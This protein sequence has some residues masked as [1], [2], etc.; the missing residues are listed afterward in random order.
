MKVR[1]LKG[2]LVFGVLGILLSGCS[3]VSSDRALK[4]VEQTEEIKNFYSLVD[5]K[6]EQCFEKRVVRPCDTDWVTCIEDAWVV[7]IS[8]KQECFVHDGRLSFHGLVDEKDARIISRFPEVGYFEDSLYCLEDYDCMKN[9]VSDLCQNFIY[10]Q[11][12]TGVELTSDRCVCQNN[13][14]GSK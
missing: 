5:A 3:D 1:W 4:V 10:A 2:F 8:V 7:E 11:L 13:K 12:A 6:K 14:C 9:E